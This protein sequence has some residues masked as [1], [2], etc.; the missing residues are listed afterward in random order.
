VKLTRSAADPEDCLWSAGT[1]GSQAGP[2]DDLRYPATSRRVRPE[3]ELAAMV[4]RRSRGLAVESA[5][6]A[7][8]GYVG[9]C[10]VSARD[11]PPGV[12]SVVPGDEPRGE[13]DGLGTIA[14]T[15]GAAE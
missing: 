6:G 9:F 4:G 10:D 1:S 2:Y 14:N 5:M 8:A 15:V 13:I 12:G 7:V 11:V 3:T